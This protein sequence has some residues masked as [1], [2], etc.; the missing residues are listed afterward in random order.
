MAG[1]SAPSEKRAAFDFLA[2]DDYREGLD[3]FLNKRTPE[4]KGR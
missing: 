1:R 2:T 3:A 4:F